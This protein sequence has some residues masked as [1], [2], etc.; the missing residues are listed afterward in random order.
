MAN[1]FGFP[2]KSGGDGEFVGV[3]KYD[4]K[5]G[6][7]FRVDRIQDAD[8]NYVSDQVDITQIVKFVADFE[9]IEVGN[10]LFMPGQA[11]DFQLV[12]MGEP[13]PPPPTENHKYG[14]RFMV[15]LSNDCGGDEPVREIAGTSK[16]WLS[17]IE[18]I[19]PQYLAGKDANP[20]KLP[21]LTVE[22][23]A[24]VK[25]GSGARTS[26]NYH[27][28]FRLSGWAPRKDLVFVP[29]A[30]DVVVPSQATTSLK[31][32]GTYPSTGG[33]APVPKANAPAPDANLADDFG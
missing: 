8:G 30:R 32:N 18:H 2:E 22:K 12:R 17:A 23:I 15:R 14:V 25:S 21:V 31:A 16:A 4:A 5:A 27:P 7:F 33:S 3:L 20:G 6:R 29:K 13:V 10:I 11:P 19:Y 1:I 28:T 26:T 9:N 24:P